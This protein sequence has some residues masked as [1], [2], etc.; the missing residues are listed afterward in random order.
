ME[1]RRIETQADIEKRE[2]RKKLIIG[3]ILVGVMILSTAGF[4]FLNNPSTDSTLI[5]ENYNGYEFFL[6]NNGLWQTQ[7]Q[8]QPFQFQFSPNETSTVDL[9]GIDFSFYSG[10][11][12]YFISENPEASD[13]IVSNIGRFLPRAQNACLQGQN[14]TEDLPEKN[15]TLDNIIIIKESNESSLIR[16]DNCIFIQG[17]YAD[18]VKWSDAF[19][20]KILGV[21]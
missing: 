14:C 17:P 15:C 11:P 18:L 10:K 7:I 2:T 5:T 19:L 16:E 8:G 9:Q 21:K 12:L 6:N 3:I 1:I 13:E 20:Y 4:A